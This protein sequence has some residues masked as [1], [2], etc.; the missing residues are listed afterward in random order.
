M[1]DPRT[2]AEVLPTPLFS[3]IVGRARTGNLFDD[4]FTV[5]SDAWAAWAIRSVAM[6]SGRDDRAY[7]ALVL[8][9]HFYDPNGTG[10]GV[11]PH[12]ELGTWVLN[13]RHLELAD[14]LALMGNGLCFP[15]WLTIEV[16]ALRRALVN[17]AAGSVVELRDVLVANSAPLRAS[18]ISLNTAVKEHWDVIEALALECD[19]GL[20]DSV[21]AGFATSEVEEYFPAAKGLELSVTYDA[22][23]AERSEAKVSRRVGVWQVAGR[24]SDGARFSLGVV[25]PRL[26]ASSTLRDPLF[27]PASEGLAAVL[28]RG[29]LLTRFARRFLGAEGLGPV[30]EVKGPADRPKPFLRTMAGRPKQK[31]A[32]ASLKAAV[33]FLQTFPE[34]EDAWDAVSG[35]AEK[36]GIL[37]TVT[38]D[39]Y[40][41]AHRNALRY[42]RRAEDPERDD[43]NVVL[44]VGWTKQGN[45]SVRFTFSLPQEDEES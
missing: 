37:L 27:D 6:M 1:Q 22:K 10:P 20:A 23:L 33:H 30:A 26:T 34:S 45:K 38:K 9:G 44:P 4:D 39:G 12:L 2:T 5:R 19:E 18:L 13:K 3:S 14:R 43:I 28:V 7:V 24:S 41:R 40:L 32:E 17:V 15:S 25:S 16:T 29:L 8:D 21:A 36:G 11:K 42:L 31:L 35:H